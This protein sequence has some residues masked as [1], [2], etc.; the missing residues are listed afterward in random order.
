MGQPG[1]LPGDSGSKVTVN[2]SRRKSSQLL[3]A[4]LLPEFTYMLAYQDEQDIEPPPGNV[5]PRS[6]PR[7]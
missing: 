6:T 7:I 1:H 4:G 2:N 5:S 3:I